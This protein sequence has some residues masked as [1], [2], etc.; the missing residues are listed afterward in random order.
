MVNFNDPQEQND[1][2]NDR[3]D[4]IESENDESINPNDKVTHAPSNRLRNS[5]KILDNNKLSEIKEKKE[6]LNSNNNRASNLNK[7]GEIFSSIKSIRHRIAP[8]KNR[9]TKFGPRVKANFKNY[10]SE[11]KGGHGAANKR[12]NLKTPIQ[13]RY[14]RKELSKIGVTRRVVAQLHKLGIKSFDDLR[15]SDI[16]DVTSRI[17]KPDRNTVKQSACGFCN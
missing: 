11:L 14:H 4:S 9:N 15:R 12:N 5:K 13:F 10:A 17:N 1:N 16:A 6:A 8:R 7:E 2:T 3:F